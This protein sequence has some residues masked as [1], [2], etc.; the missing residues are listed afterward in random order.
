MNFWKRKIKNVNEISKATGI[1]PQKIKELKEGKRQIQGKT[2]E[3]VLNAINENS[4]K[5]KIEK[6]VDKQNIYNWI[7]E[8]D[9]KKQIK[10]FNYSQ[11][12]CAKAIG[13]SKATL[14]NIVN[15]RYRVYSNAMQKIYDFF[16][17]DFNRNVKTKEK[18]KSEKK[19]TP[20]LEYINKY[21]L[22]EIK[23]ELKYK[24]VGKMAK[25]I[26]I[27]EQTLRNMYNGYIK[28]D[29][30]TVEKAYNFI[31]EKLGTPEDQDVAWY[32]STDLR[33]L[34][35]TH[36]L[37][38]KD[39]AEKLGCSKSTSYYMINKKAGNKPQIAKPIHDFFNNL[40]GNSPKLTKTARISKKEKNNTNIPEEPKTSENEAKKPDLEETGKIIQ[41]DQSND[42]IQE[43]IYEL[44]KKQEEIYKLRKQIER[45]EKLIDRII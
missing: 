15:G 26:G 22:N 12:D 44:N 11:E 28:T 18:K 8:T 6:M 34:M 10:D 39:I 45:Y 9:L 35:E 33:K 2:M 40:E 23:K 16:Q 13:V 4:K 3:K 19:A 37:K 32:E 29:T 31:R 25:D 41:Y 17:D 20:K 36:K 43:L 30:E 5:M 7:K 42:G 27:G 24:S 21:K 1:E 38:Y 14:V